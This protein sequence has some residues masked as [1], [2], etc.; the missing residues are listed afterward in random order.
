MHCDRL[1][2][3]FIREETGKFYR[4]PPI[5]GAPG[6]APLLFVGINPR[7]T[8]SSRGLHDVIVQNLD[9]FQQ[10]RRNRVGTSA[11]IDRR[12]MERHYT[13][14]VRIAEALFLGKP[15]NSIA[16]TTEL[17]LCASS[18]CV[19]LPYSSECADRFLNSVLEIVRPVVVFSVGKHVERTLRNLF[20]TWKTECFVTWPSGRAPVVMLP[21]PNARGSKRDGIARAVIAAKR[22]MREVT[23]DNGVI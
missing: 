13:T 8:T 7:V 3:P 9:R 6:P 20:R 17:H 5:I 23:L 21:H 14:H 4:F 19:G 10:L 2:L 15:F 22:Y 16:C 12:G 11:Y 18:S 1:G